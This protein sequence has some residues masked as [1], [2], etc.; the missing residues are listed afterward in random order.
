MRTN[1]VNRSTRTNEIYWLKFGVI[2]NTIDSR[3]SAVHDLPHSS[4]VSVRQSV[5][6]TMLKVM[7]KSRTFALEKKIYPIKSLKESFLSNSD[8]KVAMCDEI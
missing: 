6:N 8:N 7:V 1:P 3:E 2:D 4:K 5:T